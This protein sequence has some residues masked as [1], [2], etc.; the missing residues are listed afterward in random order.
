MRLTTFS[1]K[2]TALKELELT[3][4]LGAPVT[5]GKKMRGIHHVVEVRSALIVS[6]LSF[7]IMIVTLWHHQY[8][9]IIRNTASL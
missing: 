3:S 5:I 7:M 4:L 2:A 6:L 8:S 1:L 9:Q